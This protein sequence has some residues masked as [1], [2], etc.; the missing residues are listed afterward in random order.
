VDEHL[1]VLARRRADH[2]NDSAMLQK[3]IGSWGGRERRREPQ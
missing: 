2:I 1:N 3:Q